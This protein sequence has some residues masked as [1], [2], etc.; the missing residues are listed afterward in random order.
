M[1]LRGAFFLLHFS[2]R[3]YRPR[4][5]NTKLS[6]SVKLVLSECCC[7]RTSFSLLKDDVWNFDSIGEVRM[8]KISKRLSKPKSA[9]RL[10]TLCFHSFW[11]FDRWEIFAERLNR[12]LIFW[13]FCI[14]VKEQNYDLYQK[15]MIMTSQMSYSCSISLNSNLLHHIPFNQ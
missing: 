12:V 1:H 4:L 11:V 10:E 3:V 2:C 6:W 5:I 15:I 13:F 9:C 14:K 8:K 7:N